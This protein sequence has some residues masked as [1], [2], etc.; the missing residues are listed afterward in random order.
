MRAYAIKFKKYFIGYCENLTRKE[1]TVNATTK[2][3]ARELFKKSHDMTVTSIIQIK[4]M[5]A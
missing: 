5:E 2:A 3:E 1:T 4:E